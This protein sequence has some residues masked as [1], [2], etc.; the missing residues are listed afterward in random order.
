[1]SF[2][3][4]GLGPEYNSLVT[5]VTMT[6]DLVTLNDLYAHLMT[7]ESRIHHQSTAFQLEANA[8]SYDS[9]RGGLASS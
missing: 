1:M 2:L 4:D 8:V 9:I 3:L 5:S 7:F 6:I